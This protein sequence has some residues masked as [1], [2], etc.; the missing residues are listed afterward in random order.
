MPSYTLVELHSGVLTV[1]HEGSATELHLR[2]YITPALCLLQA[3]GGG[4]ILLP[5]IPTT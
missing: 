3:W 4:S 1:H 5:H 2:D